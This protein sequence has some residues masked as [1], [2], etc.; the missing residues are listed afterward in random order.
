MDTDIGSSMKIMDLLKCFTG[1]EL[2]K[3]Y[4][5][6]PDGT[7]LTYSANFL[8]TS[9]GTVIS[10]LRGCYHVGIY[11]SPFILHS[12]YRRGLYG[13]S[14]LLMKVGVWATMI[15]V[16][17]TFFRGIGRMVNRDYLEFIAVLNLTQSQPT[18]ESY[19][20]LLRQYDFDF[21]HWPLDY[22]WQNELNNETVKPRKFLPIGEYKKSS[23]TGDL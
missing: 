4:R 3:R 6:A 1:P 15:Y 12:L 23:G 18:N 14:E 19:K 2:Y 16:G 20:R 11:L 13:S 9:G 21:H 10:L 17:A 8:E 22:G 7:P 5:I